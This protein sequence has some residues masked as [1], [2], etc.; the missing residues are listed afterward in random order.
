MVGPYSTQNWSSEGINRKI[1]FI[2]FNNL[3]SQTSLLKTFYWPPWVDLVTVISHLALTISC[4]LS[5]YIYYGQYR[6]DK[7]V[8]MRFIFYR[9]WPQ[10]FRFS[11]GSGENFITFVNLVRK[12]IQLELLK[13]EIIHLFLKWRLFRLVMVQLWK[14]FWE[15]EKMAIYRNIG[16]QELF[17]MGDLNVKR[18]WMYYKYGVLKHDFN[19]L[20]R[21]FLSWP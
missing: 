19:I 21:L 13:I 18:I 17:K 14:R 3:D 15:R 11:E 16:Y 4:S 20:W 7:T 2:C 5:F 10:G 8:R 12:W 6:A 9:N 1:W